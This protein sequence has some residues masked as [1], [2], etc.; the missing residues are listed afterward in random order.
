MSSQPSTSTTSQHDNDEYEFPDD[1]EGI[2]WSIVGPIEGDKLY[3]ETA[4]A[5]VAPPTD[6]PP[7]PGSSSS[8]YGFSDFENLDAGDFAELN[9]TERL[10]ALEIGEQT[11]PS[12]PVCAHHDRCEEALPENTPS[13]SARTLDTIPRPI[14]RLP[15]AD[16]LIPSASQRSTS[17]K[18]KLSSKGTKEPSSLKKSKTLPL[19]CSKS[20]SKGKETARDPPVEDL[21]QTIHDSF[22]ESCSCPM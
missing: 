19:E 7:R 18:R 6:L 16:D 10:Y 8:S 5:V 2:D 3:P 17:H 4:S 14:A 13:S 9:E 15:T 20:G 22:V 12:S 11:D 21:I 1:L